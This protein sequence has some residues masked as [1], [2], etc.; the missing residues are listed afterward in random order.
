MKVILS[1]YGKMGHM[2]E[3]ILQEKGHTCIASNDIRTLDTTPDP[4]TV[5]IDFS[6]PDAFRKNYP[7]LARHFK[8]VVVGTTGW[9]DLQ[10]DVEA[11]FR[12]AGTTLI[13]ASNFSVGA[14]LLFQSLTDLGQRIK[15]V[16]TPFQAHLTETHHTQKL[17][18]PS[19]TAKK[20]AHLFTEASGLPVT[21]QSERIG[22]VT[23]IHQLTLTGPADRLT[24]E[25]EAFSREGF[26]RGAVLAAEIALRL[27]QQGQPQ[28]YEFCE[29]LQTEAQN[30]ERTRHKT[31]T[32]S[33]CGTALVTPFLQGAIDEEALRQHVLRQVAGGIDF[34]VPLGT[35]A[36]TPCL[37][38]DEKLCILEIVRN[39][40]PLTPLLVGAGSNSTQAT[41]QNLQRLNHLPIQGYLLV[42]PYYNKPTQ[43]GLYEH[44]RTAA[45]N[46]DKDIILYN[47]PGRTGTNLLPETV[48]RLSEI[49]N[50]VGIKEASGNYAQICEIIRQ[51]PAN[52]AVLSGNDDETLSLMCSGAQGVISVASNLLPQAMTRLCR[53]VRLGQLADA[54][55]LHLR[56]LPFFKACFVESNPIPIK[57]ALTRLERMRDEVRLPLT[58]AQPS[59]HALLQTTLASLQD[60][61]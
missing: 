58:P 16:D 22:D 47:V 55:A 59:T 28:V 50:I 57:A 52:F 43:A 45:A 10:A 29:L 35:T 31:Q 13:H 21:L 30:Q 4:D 61:L 51:T 48:L 9:N 12:A 25:H 54:Q 27:T 7:F 37:E 19:G 5:C 49:P 2:V 42:T 32:W 39:A 56:L 6:T 34:L 38:T 15:S 17:D 26:A 18:A 36:E 44:F 8:T 14:N 1:G 11:T 23:G 33:G 60:L 40:A 20:M 3:R 24:L 53:M 41:C 46:T